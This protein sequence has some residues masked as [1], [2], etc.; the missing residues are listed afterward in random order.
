[1]RSSKSDIQNSDADVRAVLR[2]FGLFFDGKPI[3]SPIDIA[4][5]V[6]S[7][8]TKEMDKFMLSDEVTELLG[9]KLP[10]VGDTLD[11]LLKLAIT[12]RK[13]YVVSK[14]GL[15]QAFAFVTDKMVVLMHPTED[16]TSSLF[17]CMLP[18]SMHDDES[19]THAHPPSATLMHECL[20]RMHMLT[21]MLMPMLMP[22]LR[23][24]L[25]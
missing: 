2:R 24:C 6:G 10:S 8:T 20:L 1:M 23:L 14:K 21:P 3:K 18:S 13:R 4:T 12:K 9:R 11:A 19:R 22:C 15:V 7:M 17:Y 16:D 5:A 25:C